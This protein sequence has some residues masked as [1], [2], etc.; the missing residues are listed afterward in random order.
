MK[1]A[2][3][4]YPRFFLRK[5][6]TESLP[7][8]AAAMLLGTVILLVSSFFTVPTSAISRHVHLSEMTSRAG[9][10]V[11]GRIAEVRHGTHPGY[12]HI[13]VMFVTVEVVEMVKGSAAR[14]VTFMQFGGAQGLSHN[15]HLPKYQAGEEVM[16]FLYPESRYGFTSPVGEGQGKF[17][18][19]NDPRSGRRALLNDRGNR[20][21]FEPMRNEKAMS[22]LKLSGAERALVAQ[23]NGAADL[24]AFR[25][26]VRKLAGNSSASNAQ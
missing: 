18:V 4:C 6:L 8:P 3:V 20:Q 22:H 11:Y 1:T 12:N 26:L 19:S 17:M 10:I 25:S 14:Q 21:L 5:R 23:E 7:F 24:V 13:A 9:R 2:P 16:L 15:Y